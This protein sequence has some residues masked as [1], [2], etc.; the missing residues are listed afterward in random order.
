MDIE[1]ED[2][3][4]LPRVLKLAKEKGLKTVVLLNVAGPVD[5]RTWEKYADSILCI[6]I[7]GC[8]GGVAAADMLFGEAYP[9]G[10]LPVTFPKR[11]EDTPCYPNF[12]GEGNHVYYGEGIFVGYRSYEK[13][14][15]EVQYP[16][17]YGLSYTKFEISCREKER[18]FRVLEED[19][20]DISVI[21]KIQVIAREVKWY[22]F[23]RQKK[24]L[25]YFGR[26]RNWLDLQKQS[27][28][29]RRNKKY[30]CR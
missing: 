12:P 25:M 5:M 9:A 18:I 11:L 30:L 17:G 4:R 19:T 21:V 26:L 2:R 8:M 1:K 10:K 7:P 23:T 24:I 3:Q 15:V 13:R 27:W 6:F 16:F 20:L 14:K 22:R 28:S 29:P